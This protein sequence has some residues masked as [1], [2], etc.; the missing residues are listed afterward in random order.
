ME[1]AVALVAKQSS[2]TYT[3]DLDCMVPSNTVRFREQQCTGAQSLC[4]V[5]ESI[6]ETEILSNIM[7]ELNAVNRDMFPLLAKR[8]AFASSLIR[9]L[10]CGREA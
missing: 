9:N 2:F 7:F 8:P 10:G 4:Y 1:L 6:E 5:K 3:D